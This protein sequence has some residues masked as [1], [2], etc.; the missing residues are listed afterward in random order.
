MRSGPKPRHRVRPAK[1]VIGEA[2]ALRRSYIL[3]AGAFWS[4]TFRVGYA[5]TFIQL[6]K[7]HALQ[8]FGVKEQVFGT[9]RVDKSITLVRQFLDCAFG[10]VSVFSNRLWEKCCSPDHFRPPFISLTKCSDK[11][12]ST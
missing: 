12:A 4:V 3:G 9:T 8:F 7:T 6:V 2:T 11:G 5:L 1:L 10:H